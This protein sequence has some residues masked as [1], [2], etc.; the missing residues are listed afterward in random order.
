M[1]LL[2][3]YL[4]KH[5]PLVFVALLLAAVNQIFSRFSI[6]VSSGTSLT[7]TPLNSISTRQANSFAASASFW[8]PL[9]ALRLFPE[10]RK[11]FRLL[12]EPDHAT[13]WRR[14]ICGRSRAFP[15]TALRCFRR[16]AQRRDA[17]QAQKVRNDVERFIS[18][19][20]NILFTAT[21]GVIF[22]TV[23]A[24]SIDWIIAP[25]FLLTVPVLGGISSVL[26]RRSNRSRKP[27]SPKLQRSPEPPPNPSATSNL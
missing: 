26:S 10:S 2:I 15:V 3:R 25:A 22:V 21:V 7:N 17:W 13:D 4:K 12:R 11:I 8:L 24:F 18:A 27:S 16:P 19:F 5:W 14:L 6:P 1:A 20:V 9:W 23:Y